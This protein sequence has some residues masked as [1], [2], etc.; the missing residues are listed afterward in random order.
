MSM[1][2]SAKPGPGETI[3][4]SHQLHWSGWYR[5]GRNWLAS[6]LMQNAEERVSANL[7]LVCPVPAP[8]LVA[9]LI[10]VRFGNGHRF[11]AAVDAKAEA[12]LYCC[13]HGSADS[14]RAAWFETIGGCLVGINLAQVHAIFWFHAD[15]VAPPTTD[16]DCS[17]LTVHFADRETI[18][19]PQIGGQAI[20]D[21]RQATLSKHRATPFCT[22]RD[23]YLAAVSVSIGSMT[24]VTMP[25]AWLA[26]D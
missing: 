2:M 5:D 21:F 24:Y 13:L 16:W 18:V 17:R 7:R 20:A 1:T 3:A 19:L 8:P 9:K 12:Y 14:A 15:A 11:V 25:V 26:K 10:E 6:H 23:G 4:S 22:L